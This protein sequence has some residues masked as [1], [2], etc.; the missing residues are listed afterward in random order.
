MKKIYI[1]LFA[2]QFVVICLFAQVSGE[3]NG[4]LSDSTNVQILKGATILVRN[5]KDSSILKNVLSGDGGSFKVLDLSFGEYL[6]QISFAGYKSRFRKVTISA[7]IPVAA[8][9]TVYL[10]PK[11]NE[12]EGVVVE[13][14]PIKMKKDTVE[15]NAGSFATKPN[16]VAEDLLKKMPGMQVDA[17]GAVTHAGEKVTRVLVDGKRFF[18]D[19]P[20]LATRNL[21]PDVI[22]KIQVFDDLSDQSKFTG[23]DDGN[24]VKTINIVT[25][26][27][28]R[29]G[30]FGKVVAGA[31]TNEAYD[32]SVNMHRFHG[33]QQISLLAQ[34][35]DLNK[36]NFSIQDVLGS[37][38]GGGGGGRRGGGGGGG[39]STTTSPGI[40]TVAAV[41]TNYKDAWGKNTD[42]YG[43]YFFNNQHV[44]TTTQS[45]SLNTSLDDSTLP[46]VKSRS[47]S[48]QRTQSHRAAFNIEHRFDSS[49][50]LIFRPN[51]SFQTTAPNTS[52]S[53]IQTDNFGNAIT[54][55]STK[56]SSNNSGYSI[57]NANLQLRHKFAK[58]FRTISLDMNVNASANDGDGLTYTI[59][60]KFRQ[61]RNDTLNQYYNDSFHSITLNPTLSYTEPIGKNQI[62][63]FDYSYNYNHNTS[64]NNTYEYN[65]GTKGYSQFDSLFSNSYKF[66]SNSN[67]VGLSY[68]I[69]NVKYN[70]SI[71][72]GVQFLSFNNVNTTKHITVDHS[73]V[74]FTPT[75][76]FQYTF[77]RTSNLRFNYSGRTGTPTATQL[78]P[79]T[80]TTD[81]LNFQVGNPNLKPQFIHSLRVLYS[82]FDAA[83]GRVMFATINAS[84]TEND[85]QSEVIV[86]NTTKGRT[87]TYVNLGGT[88]NIGGFFNYGFAL[89]NP[90][91]N[92]NFIT[93]FNYSQSQTIL[94]D[95]LQNVHDLLPHVYTKSTTIGETI[96]W[97]T[98]IKKNFDMNLSLP[99]NYTIAN[100]S[101]NTRAFY[102]QGVNTELTAYTNSG[103][104]FA[105]NFDCTFYGGDR[106]AP[107]PSPVPVF[108]PSIAKQ[109]F[110]KKD[111]ELRLSV[112]DLFN[113]NQVVNTSASA[114]QITNSSTN[115]LS[116]YVALTFT[117]NLHNFGATQQR[118][119][120]GMPGMRGP[121]EGGERGGG[122]GFGGGRRG[123]GGGGDF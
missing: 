87:S 71:G 12:L 98:N 44:T 38:A 99:F 109:M 21:P 1:I 117:Y 67:R 114:Y 13:A 73:Y 119:M 5:P 61:G 45:S 2:L 3:I 50:S 68:R 102:T 43:S 19:D 16:A 24:R 26:K 17:S 104:L 93:N 15:Y 41:G 76:N 64:I 28:K 120:P 83:S 103:W 23:F 113:K 14:S 32:A 107:N 39:G 51:V 89:K 121:G 25:K 62:L 123:G 97:T 80:T 58:P 96:S 75:V 118:R 49:N 115:L 86:N 52:S 4:K 35:N 48:I 122:G 95:S 82:K 34:A 18:S 88:Y 90:K 100:N 27:D 92:L 22:D 59:N 31:G 57:N 74:N 6:L 7:L 65:N 8:L 106:G 91:S 40:T 60:N 42:A 110:K 36:Q 9:G 54:N 84:A 78:Q 33:D 29:E 56:G 53:T 70:F 20:K 72:S 69:Q 11:E 85:I 10:R 101:M 37:A 47:A 30:Y 112:F 63:Q 77:T 79:L 81:N 116:R 108:S 111:G 55:T 66:T 105:A 94:G 46:N